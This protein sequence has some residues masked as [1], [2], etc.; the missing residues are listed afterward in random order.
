MDLPKQFSLSHDPRKIRPDWRQNRCFSNTYLN[1]AP[2][3]PVVVVEQG[4][5]ALAF[6]VGWF[7]VGSEFFKRSGRL[8]LKPGQSLMDLYEELGGRFIVV[9]PSETGFTVWT[10]PAGLYPVVLDQ[11]LGNLASSP[12]VLAE[13]RELQLDSEVQRSVGRKDNTI[14]YPFGLTPYRFVRR[15]NARSRTF[16]PAGKT[17]PIETATGRDTHQAQKTAG[18][19]HQL[20]V[21]FINAAASAGNVRAHL[22]A[23]YDSRMLLSAVLSSRKEVEFFTIEAGGD[24]A[25]LDVFIAQKLA[26]ASG[27]DHHVVKILPPSA[28][29]LAAW[30]ERVGN[31]VM[32]SVA[33]LCRTEAS[34]AADALTLQ[35]GCGEVGR[36]F[37]W[38][39]SD[40]GKR[41]VRAQEL[42]DRL[43]FERSGLLLRKAEDWLARFADEATPR[44]LD[45]AYIEQRLCCWA[46]PATM[47]HSVIQPTVSPF[48]RTQIYDAMMAADPRSRASQEFAKQF[49]TCFSRRLLDLPFNRAVGWR[50][51]VFWRQEAKA[52]TA[53]KRLRK[54]RNRT[55]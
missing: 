44:I 16:L 30:S 55:A 48:N 6:L 34:I 37:Y 21:D 13:Y 50:R 43:G 20:V 15:L 10:D 53:I 3:V 5:E 49:I 35:G 26:R 25:R 51:L 52:I 1:T 18:Y 8:T 42:L 12:R 17:E 31:C 38:S 14:W 41:G 46:G 22:T 23:G 29:D 36:A 27:V 4:A 39:E 28:S 32:D 2:G 33:Q 11:D 7:H 24:A 9:T 47:G 45:Q 19:V 40:I 54:H